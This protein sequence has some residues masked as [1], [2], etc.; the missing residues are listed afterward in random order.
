[1]RS[2]WNIADLGSRQRGLSSIYLC[3]HR[4]EGTNPLFL[5]IGCP[6]PSPEI[7]PVFKRE[8]DKSFVQ[9]MPREHDASTD[10]AFFI[11]YITAL[12]HCPQA[13]LSLTQTEEE[14]LFKYFFNTTLIGQRQYDKVKI[15][16]M[17]AWG[18][19]FIF[20]AMGFWA[21]QRHYADCFVPIFDGSQTTE[22]ATMDDDDMGATSCMRTDVVADF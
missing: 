1:L 9:I 20:A 16:I 5:R 4:Y 19:S 3:L 17:P 18:L 11:V 21:D 6:P 10:I 2:D 15:D 22:I 7:E 8:F 12:P 13:R 14:I